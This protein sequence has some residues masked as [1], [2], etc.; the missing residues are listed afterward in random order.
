MSVSIALILANLDNLVL[1]NYWRKFYTYKEIGWDDISIKDYLSKKEYIMQIASFNTP[2]VSFSA[3]SRRNR[4]YEVYNELKMLESDVP[5]EESV[6]EILNSLANSYSVYIITARKTDLQ[7]KTLEVMKKL[8]FNV[9]AI[10]FIFLPSNT[11]L[12]IFR[13]KS[14]KKIKEK[15]EYGVGIIINPN[16]AMVFERYDYPVYGF[17]SLKENIDFKDKTHAALNRWQ[18]LFPLLSSY[19]NQIRSHVESQKDISTLK[20]I[21]PEEQ[22]K[23]PESALEKVIYHQLFL[24]SDNIM[25]KSES[26]SVEIQGLRELLK[27][28]MNDITS[29]IKLILS[30]RL[31]LFFHFFTQ[32]Y[33]I[34]FQEI[35]SGLEASISGLHQEV[36]EGYMMAFIVLT[37]FIEKLREHAFDHEGKNY[38]DQTF[39]KLI[40][41]PLPRPY[42]ERIKTFVAAEDEEI[43]ILYNL[44]FMA[45]LNKTY[46]EDRIK[47]NVNEVLVNQANLVL[48]KLF[49]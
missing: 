25:G 35:Q 18:S 47:T 21:D 41:K 19:H 44:S 33:N 1:N 6:V 34:D 28:F 23:P 15:Y 7:E 49:L 16:D 27:C 26:K 36:G 42:H 32:R 3:S 5:W 4:F 39:R 29:K 8:G 43:M 17:T 37:K 30:K 10:N 12:A 48:T 22:K 14:I 31:N 24:G 45:W 20:Q 2:T 11:N 46:I 38:L 9:E 13:Q 40:G